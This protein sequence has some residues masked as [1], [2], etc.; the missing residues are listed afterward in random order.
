MVDINPEYVTYAVGIAEMY[1]LATLG[2][3]VGEFIEK[4]TWK[5]LTRNLPENEL[6]TEVKSE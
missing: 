4:R 1:G 5:H 3:F 2:M 6:E